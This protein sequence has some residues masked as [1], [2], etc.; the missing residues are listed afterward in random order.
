MTNSSQNTEY[1]ISCQLFRLKF[2]K[3]PIIK[4]PTHISIGIQ[5]TRQTNRITLNIPAKV[6]IVITIPVV[7]KASPIYQATHHKNESVDRIPT[8]T[9]LALNG[10]EN[11]NYFD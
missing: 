7:P 11:A 1:K 2:I 3:S 9:S 4:M 5:S 8:L 6:S 10:L